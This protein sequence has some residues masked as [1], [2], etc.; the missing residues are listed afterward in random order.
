MRDSLSITLTDPLRRENVRPRLDALAGSTGFPAAQIAGRALVLGLRAIE[1][2]WKRLFP[3]SDSTSPAAPSRPAHRPAEPEHAPTRDT[4]PC[5]A[6]HSTDTQRTADPG[7][8][9]PAPASRLDAQADPA[10]PADADTRTPHDRSAQPEPAPRPDASPET[11][12]PA[13]AQV[14]R[15]STRATAQALGYRDEAGFRQ[16]CQRH[17]ELLRFSIKSGRERLWDLDGIRAEYDRL[18]FAPKGK[19]LDEQA[20]DR[21]GAA[22]PAAA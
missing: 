9:A 10:Q 12:A 21:L 19:A 11:T 20:A 15:I 16:H 2:D 4:T 17:P 22:D 14:G 7:T 5:D 13:T 8:P 6:P 1:Q 3:A 18:G